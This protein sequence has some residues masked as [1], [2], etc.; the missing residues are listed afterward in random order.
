MHS[1]Y[2]TLYNGRNANVVICKNEK[3]RNV[4]SN[5][6]RLC[7]EF[8]QSNRFSINNRKMTLVTNLDI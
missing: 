6:D 7:P 5:D 8:G 2:L 1:V 3:R 4:V